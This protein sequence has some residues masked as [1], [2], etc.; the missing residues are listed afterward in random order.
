MKRQVMEKH[1]YRHVLL[2]LAFSLLMIFATNQSAGLIYGGLEK[3]LTF[4][5]FA[6][7]IFVVVQ[8]IGVHSTATTFV[9]AE[10]LTLPSRFQRPPPILSL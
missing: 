5:A 7:F 6:A 2:T 9:I 10:T 8:H 1:H 3:C 4:L